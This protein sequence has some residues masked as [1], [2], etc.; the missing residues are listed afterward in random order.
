MSDDR[1]TVSR[2]LFL[3]LNH[4]IENWTE[5][6]LG[7]GVVYPDRLKPDERSCAVI[8][9]HTARAPGAKSDFLR[10]ENNPNGMHEYPFNSLL[11]PHVATR[12]RTLG[13]DAEVFTRDG[14]GIEGAYE[15]SEAWGA[16]CTVE[17]HF[18]SAATRQA[19]GTETL[20]HRIAG[21]STYALASSVQAEMV[22]A[23]GLKDR[24][25]KTTADTNG[26]GEANLSQIAEP[27]II[28]EPFFGSN[29]NDCAAAMERF[30]RLAEA[31]ARGVQHW[32]IAQR[33]EVS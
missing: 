18:N 13:I 16:D 15:A 24:G 20:I 8:I 29:P 5:R 9:G 3:E 21:L 2:D 19:T 10:N 31:I 25:V 26:R 6:A 32:F 14:G 27:S 22:K 11:A 1:I 12:L 23:L 30:E 17:L 33:A 4:F 28:V 7:D